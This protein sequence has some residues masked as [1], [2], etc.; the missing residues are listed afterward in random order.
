MTGTVT[1]D[2]RRLYVVFA[3][4]MLAMSLGALDQTI[5]AT[6]LP[7][8]VGDLG[9]L[10]HLSWGVTAYLL[11]ST[12]VT[13]LWGKLSDLYGRRGTF[14]AAIA[15]FLAGSML[16][17]LSQNMGELIAFQALQ[18]LGGGG[19]MALALAIVGDLVAPRE[20]GRYQGYFGAV[21]ALAS[22]SGP[23]LGG[24][25]TDQL[26]WRWIFYVNLPLGIVALIVTTVTLRI[27]FRRLRHRIDYPGSLLLVAGG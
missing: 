14:Q 19:L 4:L 10:N 8:I 20:R 15:I 11:T 17:G 9:G 24:Y 25:F 3:G 27:P 12:A 6:A 22:V 7:T 18:G 21:F 2:R 23:L 1:L 13:P 5:V 16:S 26:S